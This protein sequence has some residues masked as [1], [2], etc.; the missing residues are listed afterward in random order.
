MRFTAAPSRSGHEL[1]Q[2]RMK[3]MDAIFSFH[4]VA[5]A[6]VNARMQILLHGPDWPG[7]GT[8]ATLW[9]PLGSAAGDGRD[10]RREAAPEAGEAAE[11]RGLPVRT[12]DGA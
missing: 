3:M 4:R 12:H 5:A 6:I 8:L 9:L 11:A 1:V 7:P 10:G 2:Q